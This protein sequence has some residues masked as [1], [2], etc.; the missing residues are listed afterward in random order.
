MIF[1]IVKALAVC[2]R[3]VPTTLNSIEIKHNKQIL[4]TYQFIYLT[5]SVPMIHRSTPAIY[6]AMFHW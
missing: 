3:N 5:I 6:S 4:G 2:P 1:N